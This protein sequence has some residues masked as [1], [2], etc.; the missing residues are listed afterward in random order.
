MADTTTGLGTFVQMHRHMLGLLPQLSNADAGP[1]AGGTLVRFG[2]SQG[3]YL[4]RD[5]QGMKTDGLLPHKDLSLDL[6]VERPTPSPSGSEEL[7]SETHT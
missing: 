2:E 7:G 6:W 4:G 3:A 1:E 5:Q